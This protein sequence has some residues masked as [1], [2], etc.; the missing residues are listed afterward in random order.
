MFPPRFLFAFDDLTGFTKA[1][2]AEEELEVEP[3]IPKKTLH[4]SPQAFDR[5]P[6]PDN[7]DCSGIPREGVPL[8]FSEG[9][10]HLNGSRIADGFPCSI[11][12]PYD[13]LVRLS[14]KA[15]PQAWAIHMDGNQATSGFTDLEWHIQ[16]SLG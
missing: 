15:I 14:C 16:I 8:V 13:G 3:Q 10:A 4:L 6:G 5:F 7:T 9:S 11:C 1:H 12:D 2:D